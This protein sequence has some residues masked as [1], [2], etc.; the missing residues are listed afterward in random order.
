[1]KKIREDDVAA[2][3]RRS[4]SSSGEARPVVGHLLLADRERVSFLAVSS[5]RDVVQAPRSYWGAEVGLVYIPAAEEEIRAAEV[6]PPRHS[7][8][9]LRV[10]PRPD[11]LAPAL[12]RLISGEHVEMSLQPS[13]DGLKSSLLTVHGEEQPFPI[14]PKD[15][16][17]FLAAVFGFAPLGIVKT[18]MNRPS[19][20]ALSVRPAS[21]HQ[22]YR[23]RLAGAASSP[24]PHDLSDSG[25][26]PALLDSIL[27]RL[28][29]RAGLFLVAGGPCSGRSTTLDLLAASLIARGR[30]GG[31]FGEP[32]GGSLAKLD[33]LSPALADWPFPGSLHGAAPDFIVLD[34][35]DRSV[36]LVLAARLAATGIMVLAGAPAAEA[37]ALVRMVGREIEGG[38]GPMVPV[39]VLSQ[40]LVRTVCRQCRT[41]KTLPLAQAEKN[42]FHRRDLEELVRKGGLVLPGGK[43]CVECAGTGHDGLT[44]V[45]EYVAPEAPPGS[46]P[47]LRED[48]WRKVIQGIASHE[49][50][51]ILPGAH[52]PM[53]VVREIFARSGVAAAEPRGSASS[54]LALHLEGQQAPAG[55]VGRLPTAPAL[56][57]V[58]ALMA[59]MQKV[60]S[61]HEPKPG[62]LG[63]LAR[64]VVQRA[65]S[66]GALQEILVRD[67]GLE[68]TCG[69]V[70]AALLAVR[71]AAQIAQQIDLVEIAELALLRGIRSLT[72]GEGAPGEPD[73]P[74]HA[75]R[76]GRGGASRMDPRLLVARLGAERK[77]LTDLARHVDEMLSHE[78]R[79]TEDDRNRDVRAQAVALASL[80]E[81][82]I[83]HAEGSGR[84]DLPEVTSLVMEQYG[85]RF[86][87]ALFRALLR[88]LPIF[89]IASLVELSSGDLARV[90]SLNEDNH[91]RP[92]VEIVRTTGESLSEPRIVDLSRAPFL[93][94]RHR[95]PGAEAGAEATA[96]KGASG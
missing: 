79:A 76:A 43:G 39:A 41:W 63:G 28:E 93:H 50:V 77:G 33:W 83:Q 46:L 38:S 2:P 30:C 82:H 49:D 89:P 90:V 88:A 56:E 80:V 35:L 24:P 85:R 75:G 27:E 95:V 3:A 84:A 94:I 78:T 69:A 68:P 74:A 59:F 37:D 62:D 47:T 32:Q 91:F 86:A 60:G 55:S 40:S 64:A 25:L 57:V 6:S 9:W 1:M 42:G 20:I 12:S 17:G 7:G 52:R 18:G 36:D 71:L 11:L 16:L 53:R 44:A 45:F 81:S 87:P 14:A 72:L 5:H 23:I 73:G 54:P 65:D 70:N 15:A 29:C 4:D 26:S 8:P 34:R 10:V 67:Q 31:R 19:R 61:G 22:D 48:G 96:R 21:R 58:Q 66:E 92:R 13:L 51:Q